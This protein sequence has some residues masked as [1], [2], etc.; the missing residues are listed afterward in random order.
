MKRRP[1]YNGL[2]GWMVA[3]NIS[4]NEMAKVLN[5]TPN[6]INKRLNGTGADFNCQRPGSY[7]SNLEHQHHIFFKDFCHSPFII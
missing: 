1:T 3:N 4:Q 5:A 6:Y 7:T 2:K